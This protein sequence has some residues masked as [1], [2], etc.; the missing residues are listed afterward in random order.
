M[1]KLFSYHD[2]N[3]CMDS[4]ANISNVYC[5]VRTLIKP[6]NTS[7]I[8]NIIE[9]FS[10]DVKRHFRHDAL[11]RGICINWCKV[12]VQQLDNEGQN[13]LFVE[14]FNVDFPYKLKD[15]W[16][17]IHPEDRI[18]LNRIVNICINKEFQESFGLKAYSE[19]ETCVK[20]SEETQFD[21]LDMI[22]VY[23]FSAILCSIIASTFYDYITGQHKSSVSSILTSFSV[24]RNWTI[25]TTDSSSKLSQEFRFIQAIRFISMNIVIFGH[26]ILLYTALPS[27][28][29]QEMEEMYHTSLI[30]ILSNGT[31]FVQTFFF[32]SGMFLYMS[33]TKLIGSETCRKNMNFRL[34]LKAILIR[35]LRLTPVYAFL[36]LFHATWAIKTFSGPFAKFG[37]ETEK[38]F[39]RTNGWTNLIYINNY[40]MSNEP[41][42]TNICYFGLIL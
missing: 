42:S 35:Y 5:T 11:G 28:N 27:E 41:V 24:I 19:I 31:Q 1:P 4:S 6:D 39:C 16:F 17:N 12:V 25:L 18:Q 3:G 40:V 36:L 23:I 26:V 8:W 22:F 7:P 14:K 9:E 29:P 34:V 21:K 10:R 37:G 32:L 30:G 2:Y 33:L 20:S 38:L 15:E 13:K